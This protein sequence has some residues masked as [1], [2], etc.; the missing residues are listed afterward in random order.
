M[1]AYTI[2]L[3]IHLSAL[4][5]AFGATALIGYALRRLR[6]SAIC[7]AALEWLALGKA[8]ARVFPV[9]LLTLVGSGAYMVGHAWTWDAPWVDTGLAGVVFLGVVG[10]RLEGGRAKK[11]AAVLAADPAAPVAGRAAAAVADPVFWTASLVNPLVAFGV[12]FCMV[13]K[14]SAAGCAAV[15]L[16][17]IAIGAATAVPMWR[18]RGAEAPAQVAAVD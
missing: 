6:T 4:F 7:G 15:V 11:I 2:A 9:A 18:R 14:P 5:A 3:F 10:D 13:N 1:S 8:A 16:A 12:A 17:A